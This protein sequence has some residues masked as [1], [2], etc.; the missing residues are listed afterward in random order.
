MGM[1]GMGGM[2]MPGMGGMGG[3]G[4]PSFGMNEFNR[5]RGGRFG[6]ERRSMP[7]SAMGGARGIIA[8]E[9]QG[10]HLKNDV[11]RE[12]QSYARESMMRNRHHGMGSG[13][14]FRGGEMGGGGFNGP[15]GGFEERM[16]RDMND[17]MMDERMNGGGRRGGNGR[18]QRPIRPNGAQF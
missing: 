16:D 14:D 7:I 3:M 13:G 4:M 11:P 12:S 1:P 15:R 6:G 10:G 8:D 2:G 17:R 18:S 5:P 9:D